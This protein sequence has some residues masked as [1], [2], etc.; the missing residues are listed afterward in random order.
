MSA[1]LEPEMDDG[2]RM[3]RLSHARPLSLASV[4]ESKGLFHILWVTLIL[5]DTASL[6]KSNSFL[7][8]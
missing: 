7:F 5:L 6:K 3:M 2:V 1:R 8:F 4:G